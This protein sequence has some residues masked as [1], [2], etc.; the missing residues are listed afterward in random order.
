[1]K[2]KTKAYLFTVL[3]VVIILI[4]LVILLTILKNN[5][6]KSI[7]NFQECIDAGF[8]AME[9]YPRQCNDGTQTYVEEVCLN[10]CGNGICE[11]IVCLSTRCPCPET[12]DTCEVDCSVN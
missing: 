4:L 12:V 7:T 9:S 1:M 6:I 2:K 10:N 3:I 8:P 5:K 11:E